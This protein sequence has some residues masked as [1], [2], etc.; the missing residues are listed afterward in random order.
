MNIKKTFQVVQEIKDT[1]LD[2]AL[3]SPALSTHFKAIDDVLGGF[4]PGE[5]ILVSGRKG[6]GTTSLTLNMASAIT[7]EEYPALLF[8]LEHSA[9]DAVSKL[10]TQAGI[11]RISGMNHLQDILMKD[12]EK[13]SKM[14]DIPL[15]IDD[16]PNQ[17]FDEI[18]NT[19]RNSASIYG[20]KVAFIDYLQLIS[21]SGDSLSRPVLA[22]ERF[23]ALA[24]EL[25][26]TIV[27]L[28]RKEKWPLVNKSNYRADLTDI[29]KL[30]SGIT[31]ELLDKYVDLALVLSRPDMYGLGKGDD[32]AE[33]Y[34]I[35]NK[36]GQRSIMMELQYIPDR[37]SFT[38]IEEK[39][40]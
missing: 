4:H 32:K 25:S 17:S 10:L 20:V 29:S 11:T 34:I 24:Q 19:I 21:H 16:T 1:I 8:S 37:Y 28:S 2:R 13:I 23:K 22:F 3:N 38:D 26:I 12:L 33:L 14:K 6:V 15:Y 36:H 39:T 7:N 40:E 27:C 31:Y 5:L 35:H 18:E 9:S 30:G